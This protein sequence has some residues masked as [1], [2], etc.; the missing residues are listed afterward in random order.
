M[1]LVQSEVDRSR[2]LAGIGEPM[3]DELIIADELGGL[4]FLQ[5]FPGIT[6][7]RHDQPAVSVHKQLVH[8][9]FVDLSPLRK[10]GMEHRE[11]F[12]C[13][14]VINQRVVSRRSITVTKPRAGIADFAVEQEIADHFDA[15]RGIV[16]IAGQHGLVPGRV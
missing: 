14:L 3:I 5:G 12:L 9:D 4:H 7:R 16:R 6:R 8:P 1:V 11:I 15:I 13:F 10:T 2:D